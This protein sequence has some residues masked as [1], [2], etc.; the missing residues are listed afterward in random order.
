MVKDANGAVAS[1]QPDLTF[2]YYLDNVKLYYKAPAKVT[3]VSSVEATLPAAVDVLCNTTFN[4]SQYTAVAKDVTK[5]FKGWSL[6]EGGEIVDTV[7]ITGDITLYAYYVDAVLETHPQ[8]GQLAYWVDFNDVT[9][10][11][12]SYDYLDTT[13]VLVAAPEGLPAASALKIKA[14]N[15][16]HGYNVENG[17]FS[18]DGG[19]PRIAITTDAQ[20]PFPEGCYTV[21]YS[22]KADISG[23]V[24]NDLMVNGVDETKWPTGAAPVAGNHAKLTDSFKEYSGSI[25]YTIDENGVGKVTGSKGTFDDMTLGKI[26]MYFSYTTDRTKK[27]IC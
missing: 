23:G 4:A 8:Y 2:T 16:D 1:T 20:N 18:F 3:F 6:T 19:Y 22:A 5:A 15:S 14:W 27:K 9:L 24:A 21:V 11:G 17:V 10:S 26:G 7:D 13:T 25:V 12:N